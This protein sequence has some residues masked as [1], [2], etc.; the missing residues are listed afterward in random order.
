[1]QHRMPGPARVIAFIG[2][3]LGVNDWHVRILERVFMV[4]G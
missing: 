4:Q 3:D 2:M 1:M